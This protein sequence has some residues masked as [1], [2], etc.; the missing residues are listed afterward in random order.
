V[1]S[2]EERQRDCRLYIDKIGDLLEYHIS[3]MGVYMVCSGYHAVPDLIMRIDEAI[4]R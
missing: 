1:S 4:L 3:Q 2:L